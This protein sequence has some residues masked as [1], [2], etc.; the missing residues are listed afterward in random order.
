MFLHRIAPCVESSTAKEKK[1][2]FMNHLEHECVR[3]G[4]TVD[5]HLDKRFPTGETAAG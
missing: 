3:V 4:A 1:Y 5:L 2:I